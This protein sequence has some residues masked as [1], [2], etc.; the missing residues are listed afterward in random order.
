MAD[1]KQ[2][3]NALRAPKG[4]RFGGTCWLDLARRLST[5]YRK[6][7]YWVCAALQGPRRHGH[8]RWLRERW[9]QPWE[10]PQFKLNLGLNV[11]LHAKMRVQNQILV[12]PRDTSETD[13]G[14]SPLVNRFADPRVFTRHPPEP[15]PSQPGLVR[16]LVM[17]RFVAPQISIALAPMRAL[18]E[19]AVHTSVRPVVRESRR[20]EDRVFSKSA[21]DH[22]PKPEAVKREQL[23]IPAHAISTPTAVP[24]R[25]P[26]VN[27]AQIAD[28]VMRLLDHRIS[29]WRERRGRS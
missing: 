22:V 23:A 5:R 26:D 9:F 6:R 24:I 2:L 10:S 13:N 21:T 27:V 15:N 20:A 3:A 12:V 28:Q 18:T 17:E 8:V 7:R 29:A 4:R 11:N 14:H 1:R 19:R 25:V 16:H